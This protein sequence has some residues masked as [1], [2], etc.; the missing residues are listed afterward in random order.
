GLYVFGNIPLGDSIEFDGIH[1]GDTFFKDQSEIINFFGVEFTLLQ[2]QVEVVFFESFQ[3]FQG[4]FT[5]EGGIC[6][7]D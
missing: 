1:L 6:G 2:F 7:V 4:S 5:M 3:D